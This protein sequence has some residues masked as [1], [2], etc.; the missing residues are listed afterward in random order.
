MNVVM[1][2]WWLLFV[3]SLFAVGIAHHFGLV[4]RL[5]EVDA[6]H[7]SFI[8]L[9]LYIIVTCF[10]GY[11]SYVLTTE[12]KSSPKYN[13]TLKYLHPC[14]FASET[15]MGLGMLGTLIGF[16]LMMGPA[17]G[18]LDPSNTESMKAAIIK[19]AMGMA[20][21]VTTTLIG[22]TC[23]LLTKA[24]LINLEMALPDELNEKD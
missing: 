13:D 16:M 23:S 7:L 2:R 14:W 18:G 17:F 11:V 4:L 10:I 24:Q 5:W 6:S 3:S 21:A 22:L 1:L 19:M 20:T 12:T 9:T 8:I 15:M